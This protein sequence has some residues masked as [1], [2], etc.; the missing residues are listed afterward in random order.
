[1]PWRL[2]LSKA[3]RGNRVGGNHYHRRAATVRP[4]VYHNVT[5]ESART[6]VAAQVADNGSG[7]PPAYREKVL[8]RFY[9]LEAS[10]TT[11]GDGLGL[12]VVSAIAALHDARV[13]LDDNKPGLRC[14]LNFPFNKS[15]SVLADRKWPRPPNDRRPPAQRSSP[16]SIA[17]APRLQPLRSSTGWR[18]S[19]CRD[20]GIPISLDNRLRSTHSLSI[21]RCP[22]GVGD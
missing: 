18:R 14:L 11:A 17:A 9:R 10:R 12:S 6:G 2:A 7:I 20:A 4:R 16:A 15:S 13:V 1:M 5:A 8:Q 3:A 22:Q 21:V 19:A